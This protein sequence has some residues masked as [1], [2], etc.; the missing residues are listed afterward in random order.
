LLRSVGMTRVRHKTENKK[1]QTEKPK[2]KIQ[3]KTKPRPSSLSALH[4]FVCH[5]LFLA[6]IPS[7]VERPASHCRFFLFF[8][9]SFSLLACHPDEAER[10]RDLLPTSL[11][12]FASFFVLRS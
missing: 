2:K 9:S 7:K 10:T 3:E 4:F 5:S 12:F 1:N 11:P 8:V 6:V